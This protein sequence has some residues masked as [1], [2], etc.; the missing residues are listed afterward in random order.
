ME[1]DLCDP[2]NG[3]ISDE[4]TRKRA[5]FEDTIDCLAEYMLSSSRLP[6]NNPFGP[7]AATLAVLQRE[8]WFCH[9]GMV[10]SLCVYQQL[11]SHVGIS[12]RESIAHT[13]GVSL[14]AAGGIMDSTE[15]SALIQA[16]FDKHGLTLK[17]DLQLIRDELC[18]K[19]LHSTVVCY[20]R[21]MALHLHEARQLGLDD[22]ME[23][24]FPESRQ[25]VGRDFFYRFASVASALLDILYTVNNGLVTGP[26]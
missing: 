18:C 21:D 12:V 2:P 1:P 7:H 5:S 25:C 3:P 24:V 15:L 9:W 10:V 17:P 20:I 6:E 13:L 4:Q 16:E 23:S 22:S 19:A 14:A 8:V 26:A 11:I